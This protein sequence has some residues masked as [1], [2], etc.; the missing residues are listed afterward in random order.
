RTVSP[1]P[2]KLTLART[3]Q[4]LQAYPAEMFSLA[5]CRANDRFRDN[6][7]AHIQQPDLS[8]GFL[9]EQHVDVDCTYRRAQAFELVRFRPAGR[10]FGFIVACSHGITLT[11]SQAVRLAD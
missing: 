2:D 11:A 3:R 6:P 1:T 4:A 10:D 8:P 9:G 5:D 7:A